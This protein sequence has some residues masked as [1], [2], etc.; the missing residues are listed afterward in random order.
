MFTG[1]LQLQRYVTIWNICV[2]YGSALTT[3]WRELGEVEN[4]YTS[5][6]FRL[7]TTFMPKTIRFGGSLT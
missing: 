3:I 7:F 1:D 6:N 4:E 5:Y 2:L